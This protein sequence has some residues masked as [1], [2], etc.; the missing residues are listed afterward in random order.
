MPSSQLKKLA[1]RKERRLHRK[2]IAQ[3]ERKKKTKNLN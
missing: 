1:G 2:M 3:K